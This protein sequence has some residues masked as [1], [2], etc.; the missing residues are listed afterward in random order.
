MKTDVPLQRFA[1]NPSDSAYQ[2]AEAHLPK[3]SFSSAELGQLLEPDNRENRQKLKRF[4]LDNYDLFAPRYDVTL[5][6]ERDLAFKRL[7]AVGQGGFI[8]V[9]DFERNPLNIF[10]VDY[11]G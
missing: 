3:A 8:S 7:Q 1:Q 9:L 10:A 4:I 11:D 6:E 2:V 5:E